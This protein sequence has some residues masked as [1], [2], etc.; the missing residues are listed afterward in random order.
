MTAVLSVPVSVSAQSLQYPSRCLTDTLEDCCP[1]CPCFR[2]I[3]VCF[4]LSAP[5][6]SISRPCT[7]SGNAG[8][9]LLARCHQAA[10]CTER[11]VLLWQGRSMM[12][13]SM[14]AWR[15]LFPLLSRLRLVLTCKVVRCGQKTIRPILQETEG[16]RPMCGIRTTWYHRHVVVPCT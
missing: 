12:T 11:P 9:Q 3:F 10:V 4:S 16:T 8:N 14:W 15:D 1:V 13:C 6:C 5:A 2:S 7:A